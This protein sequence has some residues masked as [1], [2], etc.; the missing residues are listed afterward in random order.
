MTPNEYLAEVLNQQTFSSDAVEMK[1]LRRRRDEIKSLLEGHFSESK[2]SIR[3]AGSM[4]KGTMIKASYDGDMTCYFDTQSEDEAAGSLKTIYDE[5]EAALAEHYSVE[6]KT[7][8]LRVRDKNDWNS[9]FHIDVVPGRY[10]DVDCDDVFLYQAYGEKSRLKTNL[11][12]HIDHIRDSGVRAAIRLMKYWRTLNGIGSAKTFVLEL[13]VVKILSGMENA[14]LESQLT[15]VLEQSR[16]NSGNLAVE[17]PANS[18]NDLKPA[19]DQC[20]GILSTAANDTLWQIDNNGWE[21]VFGSL[22][23]TNGNEKS[24]ALKATISSTSGRTRPWSN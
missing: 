17:D 10:I 8:A 20:R 21:A 7:S 13:L 1:D 3:W 15:H 19:L 9:D 16:D 22:E 24:R 6:R 5:V 12:V 11:Q 2:P 18:N 14:S 4:A 23:G